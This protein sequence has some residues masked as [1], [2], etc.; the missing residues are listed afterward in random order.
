MNP[1][2][3]DIGRFRDREE[4]LERGFTV[5]LTDQEARELAPLSKL[6]REDWLRQNRARLF[7]RSAAEGNDRD[8][9]EAMRICELASDPARLNEDLTSGVL[10]TRFPGPRVV[11]SVRPIEA[12]SRSRARAAGPGGTLAGNFK[13]RKR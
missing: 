9:R 1:D 7:A 10:V 12:P 8:T 3:M 6:E 5:A 13:R 4:A 11:Q 2:T